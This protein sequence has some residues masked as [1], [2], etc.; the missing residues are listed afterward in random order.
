[1]DDIDSKSGTRDS[2]A[3]KRNLSAYLLYQNAMRDQFKADN[4]GMTFGQ[5]SKYTSHMYTSLTP[6]EKGEWNLR[7]QQDKA[8]FD[9]EM[10]SYVPPP[11][12]DAQGNLVEDRPAVKRQKKPKDPNAPKRARGSFVFFTFEMRPKIM[13]EFPG[14]KFIEMGSIMGERWRA[15]SPEEKGRFEEMARNDKGRFTKEMQE[16]TAV[17]AEAVAR[18]HAEMTKHVPPPM[19]M[20][21]QAPMP[22]PQYSMPPQAFLDQHQQLYDQN[23]YT[24][25]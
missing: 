22:V 9:E 12:H 25:S 6:Q 3:P 5:L 4:P 17:K 16:Y 8:R 23:H 18:T 19:P 11:G 2:N 10:R 15:L 1:M 13:A 14:I 24:Y 7:A 21:V 20:P